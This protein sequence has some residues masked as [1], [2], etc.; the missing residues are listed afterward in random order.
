MEKLKYTLVLFIL[1]SCTS[2]HNVSTLEREPLLFIAS[3]N[4]S[5]EIEY[6]K[7][8]NNLETYNYLEKRLLE[9][10]NDLINEE[11]PLKE[12]N[13]I[14]LKKIDTFLILYSQIAITKK[15]NSKAKTFIL[16]RVNTSLGNWLLTLYGTILYR[17][18]NKYNEENIK[19][20]E[21]VSGLDAESLV[22]HLQSEFKIK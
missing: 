10:K 8:H 22:E 6:D 2:R 17:L 13:H 20:L 5:Y 14:K 16:K 15:Y 19:K 21:V 12:I 7:S 11:V 9:N 18:E 3:A 1:V 4:N